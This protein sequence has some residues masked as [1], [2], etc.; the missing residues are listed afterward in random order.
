MQE[1]LKAMV[2]RRVSGPNVDGALAR[3]V[4]VTTMRARSVT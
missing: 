3:F 2:S 4:K 1:R